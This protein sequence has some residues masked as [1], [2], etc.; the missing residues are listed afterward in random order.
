MKLLIFTQKVDK[1]DS[2]LGFFHEWILEFSKKFDAVKVICLY[3]GEYN[4]PE[5]VEV[6]SLGKEN[7]AS[8]ISQ[9]FSLYRYIFKL[10]GQYDRVFVHMNPIYL[11]LCGWYWKLKGI[12]SY[13]WYVHKSVDLKLRIA[14]S[15]VKKVFTSAKESFRLN[16]DKVVYLGHGID[17]GHLPYSTH[18]Y[19]NNPLEIFHVGRVTPIKNIEIIILL[20]HELKTNG[21]TPNVIISGDSVTESDKVYKLKLDELI[22]EKGLENYVTF[23]KGVVYQDLPHE[24]KNVNI[25]INMVPP[26]GM[27]KVVLTSLL[28]GIPVF[29]ANT[30]FADVFGEYRRLFMYKYQDVDDLA[31]KVTAFIKMEKAEQIINEL[32]RKVRENY[33]LQKLIDKV[34]SIMNQ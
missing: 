6:F 16:T 32:S 3:K 29:T 27:D 20:A 4:L 31:R 24:L 10:N 17:V 13:M 26:G 15:L 14:T 21:L 18:T 22:R 23:R 8:S 7:G 28:L 33:S 30:A 25:T 5:N 11:V 19:N 1:N 2:T 9:I 12:P 34:T